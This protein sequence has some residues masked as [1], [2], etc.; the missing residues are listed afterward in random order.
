[1]IELGGDASKGFIVGGTSAGG[2]LAAVITHLYRDE[3]LEPPLTG[4]YLSIPALLSAGACPPEYLDRYKS[5]E[6]NK[7]A[8][9]L[10]KKAIDLMTGTR[11]Q[12]ACFDETRNRLLTVVD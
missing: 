10:P 5:R 4:V 1:M 11:S 6:Q 7:D 3:K 12:R 2:N 8:L 9:V